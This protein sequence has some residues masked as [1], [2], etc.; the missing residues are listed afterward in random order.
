MKSERKIN[1][2][3][4][5]RGASRND[6]DDSSF[7]VRNSADGVTVK[8]NFASSGLVGSRDLLAG[9]TAS[10]HL[11]ASPWGS[12]RVEFEPE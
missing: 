4:S 5:E 6:I 3:R 9:A 8:V 7:H 1:D 11:P 2:F 12:L 10:L